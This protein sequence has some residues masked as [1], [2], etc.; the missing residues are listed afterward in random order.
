MIFAAL[1][2]ASRKGELL[3]VTDGMCR[4]HLR[5]DGVVVIRE[6]IVLPFRRRTGVGRRLVEDVRTRN[7]GKT[8]LAKCPAQYESNAFWA[9]LGFHL[10][11]GKINEWRLP[12]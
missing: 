1:D 7:P 9:A 4:W 11:P 2:E 12:G 10:T 8:L 5:R 3:L 6:L